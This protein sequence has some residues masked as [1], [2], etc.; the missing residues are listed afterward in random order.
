MGVS[1]LRL[2]TTAFSWV[3]I[4]PRV[5]FFFEMDDVYFPFKYFS[6]HFNSQVSLAFRLEYFPRPWP[7]PG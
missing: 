3:N 4:D 1:P 7:S 5:T 2:D 6:N